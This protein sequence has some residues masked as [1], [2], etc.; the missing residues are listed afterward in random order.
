MSNQSKF[1]LP[2]I[3]IHIR[4]L[5]GIC[6]FGTLSDLGTQYNLPISKLSFPYGFLQS[7]TLLKSITP[8]NITNSQYDKYWKDTLY[9]TQTSVSEQQLIISDFRDSKCTTLFHYMLVYLKR[10]VILLH[11]LVNSVLE[12]YQSIGFNFILANKFTLSSISYSLFMV[13]YKM[14]D[15]TY[16][17]PYDCDSTFI[18]SI[19]AESVVGGYT[20]S[21][22]HG[23]VR[24][25]SIYN[26]K[27]TRHIQQG[28]PLWS[29]L[30]V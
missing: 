16:I 28:I 1:V 15:H 6:P 17:C 21:F 14:N 9:G 29:I 3:E 5:R 2:Q 13:Y 19:L 4:D 27:Y 22:V 11:T 25:S 23:K 10:D 26:F 20:C 7:T 30:C 18:N 12:S 24:S 8:N